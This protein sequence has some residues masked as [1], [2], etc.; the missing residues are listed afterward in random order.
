MTRLDAGD[1]DGIHDIERALAVAVELNSPVS[2]SCYGNLAD[3]R[4][5]FGALGASA[6]APSGR[7]ARGQRFGVL[8]QVRRFRAEQAGDLYYRRRLGCGPRA[9]RRVPDA[10]EAGSPHRG[11]GEARI[12]RGRIR[13]PAARTSALEDAERRWGS[14]GDGRAVRPVPSTR[15]PRARRRSRRTRRAEASVAELLDGLTAG[16]PFWGAWSLPDLRE[17][18]TS[19]ARELRRC[20]RRRRR[21]RAG[22]TLPRV[23]RRRLH[24]RRRHLRDDRLAAGRGRRTLAR[25][26]AGRPARSRSRRASSSSAPAHSSP[27]W[28]LTR[29]CAAQRCSPR[30]DVYAVLRREHECS[31]RERDACA[32]QQLRP[33]QSPLARLGRTDI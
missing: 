13:S 1:E 33:R 5:Y 12:H 21:G 3:M 22:T 2:L 32:L 11:L 29:T 25:R 19:D 15:V 4:R 9:C 17:R 8:L 24:P 30:R 14:R 10:I 28:A 23:D 7:R 26:A 16:Q 27:A 6:D 18:V 20:S 31:V